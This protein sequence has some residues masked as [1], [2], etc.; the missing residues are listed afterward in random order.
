MYMTF[1]SCESVSE[2]KHDIVT[3]PSP[4]TRVGKPAPLKPWLVI[5][6]PIIPVVF[7]V[8]KLFD[9]SWAVVSKVVF[10]GRSP[11]IITIA[12]YWEFVFSKCL[13]TNR[14]YLTGLVQETTCC[15]LNR[16]RCE[17]CISNDNVQYAYA[18][19]LQRSNFHCHDSTAS[20]QN[21][22][23]TWE[24]CAITASPVQRASDCA[25]FIRYTLVFQSRWHEQGCAHAQFSRNGHTHTALFLN[26][27]FFFLFI[28]FFCFSLR[29]SIFSK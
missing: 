24:E 2:K 1:S 7:W 28:S 9:S 12:C 15:F 4:V 19:T 10:D 23:I 27:T 14:N 5:K 17:I 8:W 16:W 21:L 13:L 3:H 29:I 20:S 25:L 11:S 22:K 26:V 6:G 18:C